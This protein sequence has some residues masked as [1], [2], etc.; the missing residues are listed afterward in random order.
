MIHRIPVSAGALMKGGVLT[1]DTSA[2][3]VMGDPGT[4]AAELADQIRRLTSAAGPVDMS[5]DGRILVLHDPL[6]DPAEFWHLLPSWLWRPPDRD[7][8]PEVLLR[9]EP[10]PVGEAEPPMISIDGEPWRQARPGIDFT[11]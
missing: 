8:L 10:A 1:W 9:T 4:A 11:W 2:R 7:S 5:Y 6:R 3:S